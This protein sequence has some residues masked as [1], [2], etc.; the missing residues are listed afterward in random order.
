MSL[1]TNH[2]YWRDDVYQNGWGN[3][4]KSSG[5]LSIEI[6]VHMASVAAAV[7]WTASS[8]YSTGPLLRGQFSEKKNPHKRHPI[9]SPLVRDMGYLLWIET[10]IYHLSQSVQWCMQY[11]SILDR[12]L[13]APD[14][15]TIHRSKAYKQETNFCLFAIYADLIAMTCL[16]CINDYVPSSIVSVCVYLQ[17]KRFPEANRLGKSAIHE[18]NMVENGT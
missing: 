7:H 15:I 11:H 13:T 16:I 2:I 5:T 12:V 8:I 3:L 9:A 14:S 1:V 6:G 10:L 17:N 18:T 4:E